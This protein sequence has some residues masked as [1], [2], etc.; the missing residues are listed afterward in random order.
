M[1]RENEPTDVDLADRLISEFR[2]WYANLATDGQMPRAFTGVTRAGEQFVT[3][4]D[5]LGLD[6]AGCRAYLLWLCETEAVIAYAFATPFMKRAGARNDDARPQLVLDIFA[7]SA[8]KDAQLTLEAT[9]LESGALRYR[10]ACHFSG[11][12]IKAWQPFLGLQRQTVDTTPADDWSFDVI[13][14]E[15]RGRAHWRR[16]D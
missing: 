11:E 15:R 3:I 10:E 1:T 12:P 4:I 8:G 9:R 6:H 7:S 5:G 16:A 2:Q 13:W 14:E